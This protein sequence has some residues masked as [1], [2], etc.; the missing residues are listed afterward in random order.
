MKTCITCRHAHW[1][2]FNTLGKRWGGE[3]ECRRTAG[4]SEVKTD[5]VTGWQWRDE[6]RAKKCATERT[7]IELCGREGRYWE[8]K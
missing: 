4:L 5:P 2:G 6:V 8:A 3:W 1:T 7:F